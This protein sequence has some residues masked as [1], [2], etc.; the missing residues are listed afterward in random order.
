MSIR[1]DEISLIYWK[2]NKHKIGSS[3]SYICKHNGYVYG[4]SMSFETIEFVYISQSGNETVFKGKHN[5]PK[6]AYYEMVEKACSDSR[7]TLNNFLNNPAEKFR[8][9]SKDQIDKFST[10]TINSTR[11]KD[12]SCK[13]V[14]NGVDYYVANNLKVCE[15]FNSAEINIDS[16]ELKNWFIR[17]RFSDAE[18][19]S[20]VDID[21]TEA[22]DDD[23][24]SFVLNVNS[25]ES[26]PITTQK[27]TT[28]INHEPVKVDFATVN[29][30][31]K[32]IGDFGEQLVLEYERKLLAKHP[33]IAKR[34]EHTAAIK[35][36]GCG[37]DIKSYTETGLPK[38]IEVKS[39]KQNK[40]ADFFISSREKEVAD[41]MYRNGKNYYIYRVYKINLKNRTGELIIFEPPFEETKYNMK[42]SNWKVSLKPNT[43][44][45]I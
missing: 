28:K 3:K 40:P 34:I 11:I 18:I 29:Q 15:Y 37:Y 27:R 39:T 8:I 12:D 32:N 9:Y 20:V 42:P 44:D 17:I 30:I 5:G 21:E 6:W 4:D 2:E 7:V 13:I 43:E 10:Q 24:S 45:N 41:E 35:G 14:V 1:F 36:D 22:F 16:K 25:I 38:Y 23:I 26:L 33:D 31:K 19:K